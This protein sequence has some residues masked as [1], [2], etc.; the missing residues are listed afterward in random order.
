MASITSTLN[1]YSNSQQIDF[2]DSSSYSIITQLSNASAYS[3]CTATGFTSDSWVPS[4]NQSPLWVSCKI[5]NGNNATSTQCSSSDLANRG[6]SCYGCMDTTSVFSS[7][8]T[9]SSV[10]N[11][12]N[13]R[14]PSCTTFNGDLSNV[15]DNYYFVKSQTLSPVISRTSTA[16]TS[17][18]A[19]TTALTG[20]ISTTFT[21]A[22]NALTAVAASVTDP[23]YGL[24]AGLNCKV[25]G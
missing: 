11:T 12:L 19:F 23:T 14:Y 4:D 3:S 17:I 21:N 2:T 1:S 7:Y 20:T 13:T 16:S 9:K 15:W 25:F 18:T 10:L 5:Q 24:V 8:S 22:L 6:G